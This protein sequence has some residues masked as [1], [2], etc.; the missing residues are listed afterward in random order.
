[1]TSSDEQQYSRLKSYLLQADAEGRSVYDHLQ[2]CMLDILDEN[3]LDVANRP[4]RFAEFSA[5]LKQRQFT[6]G[7]AA[8]TTS[9]KPVTEPA[10]A[11]HAARARELFERPVAEVVTSV[12]QPTPYT[13]ITTTT[14][15]PKTA[16]AV[17]SIVSD[18]KLWR[19][20]GV[21]LPSREAFHL[22]QSVTKL[23]MEK[24]LEEVRFFGKIFGTQGNY[25]VVTSKRHTEP[26][27]KILEES[28]T[29]P[30]PPRKKVEV[31]VQAEPAYKGC[32][33]LT[34]WVAPDAV[35][36]W[37]KLPD[38]T[39]QLINA[40]RKIKKLFTG[41]LSAKVVT[42]PT[43]FG[44]EREYLRA[45]LSRILAATFIAPQ[46]ALE[47]VAAEEE[48]EEEEEEEGKPKKL[49]YAKYVP[50][51]A[52]NKEYAPDEDAGVAALNDLEQWVHAEGY[53]YETGR[54]T[55]VPPKPEV[56]GEEEEEPEEEEDEGE[57]AK[58]EEERELFGPL[59]KDALYAV[60]SVPKE[61]NPEED[62]E[63]AGEEDAADNDDG[64]EGKDPNDADKPEEDDDVPDDDP[65]KRKLYPWTSR[66]TNT[67]FKK[68]SVCV[69]RS[70]RWP[71]AVAYAAQQGKQWGAVY[72][73]D[74]L[75]KTD[76]AF[77]PAP[78][79]PVQKEA[80]DMV[81]V[82]DATAA[83]E[84]LVLRGEEPKEADSEDE[85]ED[86]EEPEEDDA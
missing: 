72:F 59:K 8:P 63:E 4:E 11:A 78:A 13:T 53:I 40:A 16:P 17:P 48:E 3:T 26:E 55:K 6:Y 35:S 44:S 27:E 21:G 71:G 24:G 42:Y 34:F 29:M 61:P 14:V 9:A 5:L 50:L 39:P 69:L 19:Y 23:A 81:E 20:A 22:E 74:G 7:D 2:A 49:K 15:I 47:A 12:E 51:T 1:M 31:D 45:Q 84:K 58:E 10:V 67:L 57:E 25:L 76:S 30:K 80:P 64:E 85:K 37:E 41:N 28:N 75:K 83:N 86:E 62:E 38:T 65:L 54:Q 43:F 33:R 56:E 79:D 82:A 18:T 60:I 68:H 46:N 73:G 66:L 36:P 77:T 70:L 32:N 52:A